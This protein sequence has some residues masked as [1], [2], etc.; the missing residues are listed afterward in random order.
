MDLPELM[1]VADFLA[2]YSIG[3]TSFYREVAA[4]RIRI[5]KFG[6]ATRIARIDA[7]EWASSLPVNNGRVA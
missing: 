1:T 2:R 4:K 3:R 6:T 5:R 7:E